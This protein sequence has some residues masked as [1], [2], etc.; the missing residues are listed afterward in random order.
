QRRRELRDKRVEARTIEQLQEPYPLLATLTLDHLDQRSQG[1][2]VL[3]RGCRAQP[4]EALDLH[5]QVAHRAE[6]MAYP[7]QLV[8]EVLHRGREDRI[9][10]TDRRPQAARGDA[11]LVERLDVLANARPG[12]VEDERG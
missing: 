2:G 5:V 3:P 4:F 10:H 11:H 8:A 7:L 6:L 9:E 12:R 1:S